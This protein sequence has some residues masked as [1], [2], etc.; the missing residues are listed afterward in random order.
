MIMCKIS[1]ALMRSISFLPEE[2]R[3]IILHNFN[4]QLAQYQGEKITGYVR[5]D[6]SKQHQRMRQLYQDGKS[7]RAI[8]K[9]MGCAPRT[10]RKVVTFSGV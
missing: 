1:E 6:R 4:S 10:V 5:I 9:M 2:S 8:A 3:Q 7:V